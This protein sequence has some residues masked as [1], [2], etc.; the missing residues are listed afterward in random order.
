MISVFLVED[1]KDCFV[2]N[3]YAP[4]Y[5]TS[6]Y[7]LWDQLST[8]IE[9]RK[10]DYLCIVG[11]FNSIRFGS[12]R[13]GRGSYWNR[14]DIANF[15]NFILD[16]NLVDLQ[17]SGKRYTWYRPDSTCKSHLDHMLVNVE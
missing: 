2:I 12:E 3:I 14:G 17:L 4:N 9:Q 7:E 5:A 10:E 16:N 1:G 8:L 13:C 6:R 15:N 11:D